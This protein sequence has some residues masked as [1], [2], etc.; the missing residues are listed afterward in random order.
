ML[1][2]ETISY[3]FTDKVNYRIRFKNALETFWL[4]RELLIKARPRGYIRQLKAIYEKQVFFI[5]KVLA[6]IV[7][8][9]IIKYL[10]KFRKYSDDNNCWIKRGDLIHGKDYLEKLEKE[11]TLLNQVLPGFV[12]MRKNSHGPNTN[13]FQRQ[14]MN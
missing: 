2:I 7:T 11:G 5:D 3:Q 9:G 12:R 13:L 8:D 4:S 6:R 14:N 10:V 1:C